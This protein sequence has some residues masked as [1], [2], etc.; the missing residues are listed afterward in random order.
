MDYVYNV[1]HVLYVVAC[2]FVRK[3]NAVAVYGSTRV[4]T[5]VL[6]EV[7]VLHTKVVGRAII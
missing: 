5:E 1:V 2:T 3:Y 6:P 7:Q 4:P